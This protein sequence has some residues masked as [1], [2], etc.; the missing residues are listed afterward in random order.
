VIVLNL[1]S[2]TLN[3]TTNTNGGAVKPHRIPI[4]N[5]P[6]KADALTTSLEQFFG[7]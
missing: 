3:T 1:K 5:C 2:S 6:S 7:G 4:P